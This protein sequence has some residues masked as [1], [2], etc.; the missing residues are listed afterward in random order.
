[1][2]KDSSE[3]TEHKSGEIF[4][5]KVMGEKGMYTPGYS[6]YLGGG[7]IVVMS[8]VLL[9]K[10]KA[11]LSTGSWGRSGREGMREV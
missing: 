2:I 5:S 11:R 8:F 6:A 9:V 10:Q 7:K 4:H 3:I 1:M